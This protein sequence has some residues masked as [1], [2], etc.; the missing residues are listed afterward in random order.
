LEIEFRDVPIV[1]ASADG[2][3]F[4]TTEGFDFI[5]IGY[6]DT[7]GDEEDPLNSAYVGHLAYHTDTVGGG[8]FTINF[9]RPV[10]LLVFSDGGKDDVGID[11]LTVQA[12]PTPSAI[13]LGSLGMGITGWLKRRRTL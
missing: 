10:S 4:E 5:V 8:P 6:D 2:Y 7:F 9:S 12:V 11:N 13:L 3:V 1:S